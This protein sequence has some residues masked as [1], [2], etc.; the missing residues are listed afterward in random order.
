MIPP[1][2]REVLGPAS[3]P[4]AFR[5][6]TTEMSTWWPTDTHSVHLDRCDGVAFEAGVGG[7]IYE[8]AGDRTCEWGRV[9]EWQPPDRVVFSWYPGR[10]PATAQRV[11]VTFATEAGATRVTLVHRGWEALGAAATKTR[12]AY[13]SG[14]IRVLA[15]FAAA[16]STA[17]GGRP[18]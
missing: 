1:G 13:D 2:V 10:E 18:G 12:E 8:R 6:F 11:E 15:E 7:R 4:E 16:L 17:R 9:V 5:R 3:L 14:W